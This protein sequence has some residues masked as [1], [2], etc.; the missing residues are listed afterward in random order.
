MRRYGSSSIKSKILI[1]LTAI[2]LI[3]AAILFALVIFGGVTKQLRSNAIDILNENADNSR[4][5]VERQIVHHW[6]RDLH[7]TNS[8]QQTV[9]EVLREEGKT[10]EDIGR[11]PNLNREI[12]YQAMWPLINTLHRSYGNGIFLI[13]DGPA[14]EHSEAKTRAGVYI[15]DL[16]PRSYADDNSDLLLERGLPSISKEFGIAL[17]S[18]WEL[19]FSLDQEPGNDYFYKPFNEVKDQKIRRKNVTDY[20]YLGDIMELNPMDVKAITYSIPLTLSDGTTVGILGGDMLETQLRSQ[21]NQDANGQDTFLQV[22][23]KR[24]RGSSQIKPVVV[25]SSVF[26]TYFDK[27]VNLSCEDAED[28]AAVRLK[29]KNGDTW[30]AAVKEMDIYNHNTPFE[31]EEWVLMQLQPEHDIFAFFMEVRRTLSVSLMVSVAFGLVA[32]LLAGNIVT[33]PI[34]KLVQELRVAG[35]RERIRLRRTGINEVD[36]LID[37][38]EG[39]SADVA[40]AASRISNVLEASGVPLG[41]F[42]YLA[43][44]NQ[45]FCSRTLFELVRGPVLEAPYC[46]L[47]VDSFTDMMRR[48]EREE[49]RKGGILYSVMLHDERHWLH[50][51]QVKEENGDVIGVLTDVTADVLERKKLE[52]ERN[53]DLLTDIYNRRAFREIAEKMLDGAGGKPV[54]FVMWDLD[55]LKYVNDTYG[56][57]EGDRYIRRFADYLRT[58]E[59]E[60]AVVERHSGD[61]FMAVLGSGTKE[62]QLGRITDFM[63]GMKQI[64]LE[65]KDGYRLPLR[66]SAGIAWYPE[67]STDFDV[68][69]RYADFAMYIAKHSTKGI[70][71]EFDPDTYHSNSYLLSGKEELNHLL[72]GRRVDYAFQPIVMR[73]GRIYGYEA[74]MR[75]RMVHLK[76]VQEVLHL[77][78]TQAKLSKVEELTWLTA[79]GWFDR[80]RREGKLEPEAR[81][82]INS[83]SSTCLGAETVAELEHRYPDCLDQVVLEVTESEPSEESMNYK[84]EVMK[85]WKALI[86]IDDFGSGY[87][88]ESIL[89]KLHPDIVKLDMGL[90]RHIDQDEERQNMLKSLIPLCHQQDIMVAAEGVETYEE[91]EALFDLEVDM[92]QGYY[93]CR[94]ELEVRPLDPSIVEKL[95]ELTKNRTGNCE[96]TML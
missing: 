92:F 49:D 12:V 67:H 24:Q 85:R 38:I 73:D 54:A 44:S 19:G 80:L 88:S 93:L 71:R 16:D 23:G 89:L 39:L 15:R 36:E 74:L 77:A 32:V 11:D 48:L 22:L 6:I 18:N 26:D 13:L 78:R 35:R 60:G 37:A 2:L 84:L 81:F 3:Q 55:N 65:Q 51:E 41:V 1:P 7:T 66:A 5:L 68:L 86:A 17:D 27:D 94:P 58:L 50:L 8:I 30:Y 83:I 33:N 75:P 20:G 62:G 10:A 61:E 42:E 96:N 90:V 63:E 53:Y 4:L 40:A 45:V 52:K 91:M 56:H 72:E 79:L 64:T 29:D 25:S 28:G 95:K 21:L 69:V 31:A 70:L 47:D 82:F 46:Y 87:N 43:D 34:R 59:P 9:E 57:E 14:A 76:N